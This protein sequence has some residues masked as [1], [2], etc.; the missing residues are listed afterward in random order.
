MTPQTLAAIHAEAFT[1]QRPWSADEIDSLSKA[2]GSVLVARTE[3]FA[4]VRVVA[5]EA[6]LLTLAVLPVHQGQGLGR[7]LLAQ[8][9]RAA[10]GQGATTLFLEVSARNTAALL[11]YSSAGFQRMGHRRAYFHHRDGSRSDAI[12]M[13]VPLSAALL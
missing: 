6:E 13:Q 4:L 12:L 11:L 9:C 5:D 1:D 2:K 8:A 10:T 3:G 7:A